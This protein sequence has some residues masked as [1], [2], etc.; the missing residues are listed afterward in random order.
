MFATNV[1]VVRQDKLLA[2]TPREQE[3]AGRSHH[4]ERH[5]RRHDESPVEVG[6]DLCASLG[7]A[8][9]LVDAVARISDAYVRYGPGS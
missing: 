5:R 6:L 3:P 8:S 7:R 1:V 2:V 9:S 4:D